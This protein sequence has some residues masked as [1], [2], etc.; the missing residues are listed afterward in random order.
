MYDVTI[1]MCSTT[2]ERIFPV[3]GQYPTG[4]GRVG[5]ATDAKFSDE[6]E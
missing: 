3:S 4:S 2:A 5:V 1:Q 6:L